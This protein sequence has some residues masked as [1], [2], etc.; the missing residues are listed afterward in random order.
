MSMP[1]NSST[2]L[3]HPA[4]TKPSPVAHASSER[5]RFG[6]QKVV[7]VGSGGTWLN[8]TK[9]DLA[10]YQRAHPRLQDGEIGRSPLDKLAAA[11]IRF[12][13]RT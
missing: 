1:K 7:K 2:V 6:P 12:F 8:L 5:K 4:S 10:D 9:Q 3:Q 13:K 11:M